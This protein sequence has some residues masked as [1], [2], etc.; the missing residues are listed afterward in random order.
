[1]WRGSYSA[2]GLTLNQ[3]S[4]II[5]MQG[6]PGVTHKQGLGHGLSESWDPEGESPHSPVLTRYCIRVAKAWWSL[7]LLGRRPLFPTCRG[8]DIWHLR[9]SEHAAGAEAA[10]YCPAG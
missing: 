8:A 1:M 9:C 6:E 5:R 2:A 3:Q 7:P 10:I 4:R